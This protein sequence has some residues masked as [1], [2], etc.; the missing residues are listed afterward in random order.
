MTTDLDT[1]VVP[2]MDDGFRDV[3]LAENRWWALRIHPT[4]RPKIKFIAAYRVAPISAI[5]HIAPV[6]AIEQW[7]ED[8]SKCVVTFLQPAREIG[9][10]N[11][12]KGGHTK[13]LRSFRYAAMA[14]LEKAKTL[15][16]IW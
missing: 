14:K 2:A 6:K 16:D 12:V 13:P 9:P 7:K 15:D 10:I 3:F 1:I 11:L 5:T 8:T 4:M